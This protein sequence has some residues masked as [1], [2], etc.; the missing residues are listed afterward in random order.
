MVGCASV[1]YACRDVLI[2]AQ[3]VFNARN[4]DRDVELTKGWCDRF[5]KWHP[6]ILLRQAETLSYARAAANNPK[7][8]EAYYDLL[9]QQMVWHIIQGKYSIVMKQECP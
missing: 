8:I 4:P 3:Q 9:E 7:V 5:R 1:G 2:I 6:K